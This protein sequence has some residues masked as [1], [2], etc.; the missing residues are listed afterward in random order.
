LPCFTIARSTS[1][2]G[3][4]TYLEQRCVQL[5]IPVDIE[6]MSV[7]LPSG[8]SAVKSLSSCSGFECFGF[9]RVKRLDWRA[10]G[11]RRRR[12]VSRTNECM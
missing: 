4:Y 2:P 3:Y 11:L 9:N 12:D 7:C 6:V 1:R 8:N 10:L 5:M